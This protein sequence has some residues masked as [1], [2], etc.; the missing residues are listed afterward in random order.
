MEHWSYKTNKNS[1]KLSLESEAAELKTIPMLKPSHQKPITP[2]VKPASQVVS[3]KAAA[4]TVKGDT[5]LQKE[6]KKS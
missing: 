4:S 1:D 5:S 6:S 2:T 3:R